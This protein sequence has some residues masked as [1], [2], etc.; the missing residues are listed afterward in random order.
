MLIGELSEDSGLSRDTIRWYEKIGLINGENMTRDSNN[1]RIYDDEVLEKLILIRRSKSFGF[2]LKEI[3]GMLMLVESENLNCT[4]TI[5]MIDAK[6]DVLEEKITGLQNV[7]RKLIDL[8]ENC[9]GD[10]QKQIINRSSID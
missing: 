10:C 1:Y 7:R 3:K 8:K 4:S 5:P 9:S 2:S 6:L